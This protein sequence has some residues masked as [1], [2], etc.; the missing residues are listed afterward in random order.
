M[1]IICKGAKKNNQTEKCSFIFNGKW[2]DKI[3][4]EHQKYHQSLENVSYFWLGFDVP[5]ELGNFSGRDG[6]RV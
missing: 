5:L 3:L 2:G 4:I 6:K 1:L